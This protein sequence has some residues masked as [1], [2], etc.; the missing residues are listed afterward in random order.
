MKVQ[1]NMKTLGERGSEYIFVLL[2]FNPPADGEKH[3]L[4]Y[5]KAQAIF[6]KLSAVAVPVSSP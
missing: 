1:K 5:I 4:S 6:S 3:S 2:S